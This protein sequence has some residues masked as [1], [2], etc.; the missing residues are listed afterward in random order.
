MIPLIL[1]AMP[2]T[3]RPR[4]RSSARPAF[5]LLSV[6]AVLAIACFPGLAQAED[7]SGIQYETDV[8]T[9]PKDE[10]SNIPSKNKSGGTDAPSESESEASNS[11]TETGGATGGSDDSGQGGGTPSGQ[12]SQAG[13]GDGQNA[14]NGSQD[15]AGNIN[16][17]QPLEVAPAAETE[18]DGGSSPLVPI[19]IAVAVLAAISIGYFLYRQ[20]RD[21]GS[22]VSSPKAG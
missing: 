3:R 5:A 16:A 14:K 2:R 18:S 9:V 19:L 17:A 15:S 12:S 20:R 13:G 10:S 1:R 6:L 22:P 21:P 4:A 11:N 8:P 7:N